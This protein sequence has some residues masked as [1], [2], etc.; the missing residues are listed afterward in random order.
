MR[1][2][3]DIRPASE[4]SFRFP[5]FFIILKVE[6]VTASHLTFWIGLPLQRLEVKSSWKDC[7]VKSCMGREEERRNQFLAEVAV[8]PTKTQR[9]V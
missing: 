1:G 7:N 2:R 4:L 8:N 9:R 5:V 3:Q 6:I